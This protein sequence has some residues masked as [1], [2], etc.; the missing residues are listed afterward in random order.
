MLLLICQRAG[1]VMVS[2][3]L[4]GLSGP[5]SSPG[6]GTMCVLRKDTT[7]IVPLFTLINSWV[8]ALNL[9][10]RAQHRTTRTEKKHEPQWRR[11]IQ[12]TKRFN[13]KRQ[14]MMMII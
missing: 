7:R 10:L 9:M 11:E 5:G 4:S 14:L 8:P 12:A 6:R 1:G 2:A 13:C 3:Q